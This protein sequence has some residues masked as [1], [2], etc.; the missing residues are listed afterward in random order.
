MD[1]DLEYLIKTDETISTGVY[2]SWHPSGKYIAFSINKIEQYFHANLKKTIEVLDRN[3]DLIIYDTKNQTV[4]QVPELVINK[5]KVNPR[6]WI[7]IAIRP[8]KKLN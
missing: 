1:K 8:A 7:N 5:I 3:S 6:R 4:S 2:P